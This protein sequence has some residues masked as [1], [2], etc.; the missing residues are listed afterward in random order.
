M[1]DMLAGPIW[2]R[3]FGNGSGRSAWRLWDT[4]SGRSSSG[5]PISRLPARSRT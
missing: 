3:H 5:Y 4:S 1:A 2:S